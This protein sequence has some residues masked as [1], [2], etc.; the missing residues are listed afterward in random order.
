MDYFENQKYDDIII[1]KVNLHKATMMEASI[2][3]ARL[4]ESI[5]LKQKKIIVD[6]SQCNFIDSTFF[7]ALVF[8]LKRVR[9]NRGDIKLVIRSASNSEGIINLSSVRTIFNIYTSVEDAVKDYK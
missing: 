9:A 2:M 6:I 8:A 1:E 4:L 7:G 3:K 5:S